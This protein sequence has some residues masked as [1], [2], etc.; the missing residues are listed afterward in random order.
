M[1]TSRGI[2]ARLTLAAGSRHGASRVCVMR[3]DIDSVA[4]F[5]GKA[6]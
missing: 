6:L 4:V 1:V 5:A 2:A 3:G